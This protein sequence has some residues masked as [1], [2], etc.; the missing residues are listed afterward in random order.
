MTRLSV[1]TLDRLPPRVRRFGYDRAAVRCGVV[2][3]GL[4]AFHRAHQALVFEDALEAGDLRWGV[5]GVS[6][7]SGAVRDAL[8][9]QD[10]LHT[11]AIGDR[12]RCVGALRHMLVAP[13]DPAAVVAAMARPD[14]HLVTLTVTEKGYRL[15]PTTGALDRAD[16]A[17]AADLEHPSSPATAPGYVLAG[18]AAR[19]AAGLAPFTTIACDN[20]PGNG[21]GLRGAVL[22][23]AR[24]QDEALAAWIADHAAFPDTMVDRIVPAPTPADRAARA[25]ALGLEDQAAITTEPFWQWVMEDRFSSARPDFAR[26]GVQ[27]TGDVAPWETAKLRLLNGAHSALA[28]LGG[29]AGHRFVHE[30]I[31]EPLLARLVERLWDESQTTFVPPSGLDLIS[32]RTTLMRRF[33]DPALPHALRQIAGDGSRK[34]PPRLVEAM[35]ARARLGA[36]FDALALAVAAWIVSLTRTVQ[37]REAIDDPRAAEISDIVIHG[38]GSFPTLREMGRVLATDPAFDEAVDRWTRR[39]SERGVGYCLATV[40]E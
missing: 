36:P 7:R 6:L 2:H 5:T 32:Y 10:G 27:L 20:L 39:L 11:V 4:G 22:A 34:L 31:G 33:A 15:D 28:Y 35:Q 19:R 23:M 24:A 21:Q 29:L 17:V 13:E 38:S 25:A 9:P 12:L 30:A 3:L 14:T 16:P 26:F 1:R 18:L 37:A 40:C 8:A